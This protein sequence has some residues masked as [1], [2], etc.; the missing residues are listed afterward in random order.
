AIKI[1]TPVIFG[2]FITKDSF[3]NT[4]SFVIILTLAEFV[5]SYFLF[6]ESSKS[7][8]FHIKSVLALA[9]KRKTISLSLVTEFIRGIVFDAL[10][11]LIVLYVIYMFKTSLNLGIFTSVFAFC[12]IAISF[13]FGRFVRFGTFMPILIVSSVLTFVG[14]TYFV[15]DVSQFSFIVYNFVLATA[16]HLIRIVID[17]NFYKVSQNKSVTAIYRAEYMA[18]RELF[19]NLGRILGFI[20]IITVSL[21]GCDEM[22][23]YLILIFSGLIVLIGYMSLALSNRLIA[24]SL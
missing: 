4:A 10:D 24:K 1:I 7:K 12:S 11:L 20:F 5:F 14:T 22:L 18:V 16:T 9:L 2:W 19:L 8:A 3:I 21:L 23:K 15:L 6:F 13:I 17:I